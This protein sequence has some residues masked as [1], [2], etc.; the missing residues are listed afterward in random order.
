MRRSCY[1]AEEDM[2]RRFQVYTVFARTHFKIDFQITK[3]HNSDVSYVDYLPAR[4]NLLVQI[5]VF[6][7][8]QTL[9]YTQNMVD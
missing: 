5:I 6:S 3:I 8:P 2:N 1:S 4:M 9:F 7:Y